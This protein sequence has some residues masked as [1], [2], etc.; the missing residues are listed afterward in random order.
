V[1]HFYKRAD[2]AGRLDTSRRNSTLGPPSIP[3]C[4][5]C[6]SGSV[7][8]LSGEGFK[9]SARRN[10]IAVSPTVRVAAGVETLFAP[11]GKGARWTLHEVVSVGE[12]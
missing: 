12:V 6:L 11:T 4:A 7:A 2:L 10:H 3:S 1:V 5:E 9:T 8:R